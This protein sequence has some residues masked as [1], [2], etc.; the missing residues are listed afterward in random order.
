MQWIQACWHKRKEALRVGV[1]A[2][3]AVTAIHN[4][5]FVPLF[6]MR[7]I[8]SSHVTGLA[9][10]EEPASFVERSPIGF[11]EDAQISMNYISALPDAPTEM[12]HKGVTPRQVAHTAEFNLIVSSPIEAADKIRALAERLG[13][14]LSSSQYSGSDSNYALSLIH[15]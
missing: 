8:S 10:M 4:A 2:L 12:L 6:R 1:L 11:I 15:I 7:G 13:G 5:V 3:V 9:A 14:S